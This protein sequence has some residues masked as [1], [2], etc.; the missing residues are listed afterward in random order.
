VPP[1]DAGG[2]RRRTRAMNGRCQG[3]YCA[4]TVSAIMA[5]AHGPATGGADGR[6]RQAPAGHRP[7]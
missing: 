1:V 4:A 7:S 5:A 2:L 6:R 3:F